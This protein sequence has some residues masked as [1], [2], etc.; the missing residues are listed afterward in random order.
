[1]KKT[2]D[3]ILA[4]IIVVITGL[5]SGYIV[6]NSDSSIKNSESKKLVVYTNKNTEDEEV[7]LEVKTTIQPEV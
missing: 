3:S 1:M 5:V 4:I 2:I 6:L 7:K